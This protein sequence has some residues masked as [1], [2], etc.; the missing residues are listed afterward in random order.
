M[1]STQHSVSRS[2]ASLEKV[3]PEDGGRISVMIFW[4][5]AISKVS[6]EV[7]Q[8]RGPTCSDSRTETVDKWDVE[9]ATRVWYHARGRE[10][11]SVPFG[12]DKSSFA[13]K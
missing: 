4:T 10:D 9:D 6:V 7:D 8:T 3:W 12:S 2:R 1:N 11:S 13:V 5:V